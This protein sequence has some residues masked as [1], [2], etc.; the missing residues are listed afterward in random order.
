MTSET[1]DLFEEGPPIPEMREMI[2]DE[3]QIDSYISDLKNFTKIESVQ[4]KGGET[5][6]ADE[7]PLQLDDA[8]TAL[9]SGTA[10][11][12][13]IR[14]HH[15]SFDWSDTV[16]RASDAYKIVRCQHPAREN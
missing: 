16:F 5:A 13:Q 3:E 2:F 10:R 14:Y 1:H 7:S 9:K 8:F 12:I 15:N 6:Y 11:G 4:A